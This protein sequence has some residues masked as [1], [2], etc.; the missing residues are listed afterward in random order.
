MSGVLYHLQ[1]KKHQGIPS[2]PSSK[3]ST[4]STVVRQNGYISKTVI[5][6]YIIF[7]QAILN[8][9][10]YNYLQSQPNPLSNDEKVAKQSTHIKQ[11]HFYILYL[12]IYQ[13]YRRV[14]HPLQKSIC[15]HTLLNKSFFLIKS[16]SCKSSHIS[17]FALPI[18]TST[19]SY[20]TV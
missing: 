11:S 12:N 7:T 13:V 1:C 18:Y 10:I 15:I 17:Q 20:F 2:I 3:E 6:I 8:I 9:C 14:F 19:L 16:I 5:D 4:Q